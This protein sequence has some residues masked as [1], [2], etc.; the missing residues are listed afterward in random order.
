MLR[1]GPSSQLTLLKRSLDQ[2]IPFQTKWLWDLATLRAEL[3]Q[4]KDSRD[5]FRDQ[6]ILYSHSLSLQWPLC[7]GPIEEQ[8]LS[9]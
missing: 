8:G 3:Y 9:I 4:F 1:K 2:M 5:E 6:S 7:V